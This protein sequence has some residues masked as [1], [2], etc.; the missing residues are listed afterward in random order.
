MSKNKNLFIIITLL[1]LLIILN[2]A[3]IVY[4]LI[5]NESDVKSDEGITTEIV[6]NDGWVGI[7]PSIAVDID[8]HPHISYFD[9]GNEDLKYA[10]K[11]NGE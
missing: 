3:G 2:I 6:D 8:N 7:D 11:K 9:Q 5:R 4:L 1:I 10:Y